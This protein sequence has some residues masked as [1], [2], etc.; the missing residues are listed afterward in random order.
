MTDAINQRY[1]ITDEAIEAE[2]RRLLPAMQEWGEQDARTYLF[3]PLSDADVVR[4]RLANVQAKANN[5]LEGIY[6]TAEDEAR[7]EIEMRL[8]WDVEKAIRYVNHTFSSTRC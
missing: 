1:G 2:V 7:F 5:A 8:R 6:P 4:Q 3:T